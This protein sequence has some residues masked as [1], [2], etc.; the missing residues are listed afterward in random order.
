MGGVSG[1]QLAE[2]EISQQVIPQLAPVTEQAP[3]PVT[4]EHGLPPAPAGGSSVITGLPKA[5]A[6]L[7]KPLAP[8][9]AVVVGGGSSSSLTPIP[10]AVSLPNSA[11]DARVLEWEL[12][13]KDRL[14]NETAHEV[15][16]LADLMI[17][18]E[19]YN[20]TTLLSLS[21]RELLTTRSEWGVTQERWNNIVILRRNIIIPK[22]RPVPEAPVLRAE[23]EE[24][25]LSPAMIIAGALKVSVMIRA[26][27]ILRAILEL[28]PTD[29][30][31]KPAN[32]MKIL[33]S[34]EAFQRARSDG[35]HKEFLV[36]LVDQRIFESLRA[37][38]RLAYISGIHSW[39][40]FCDL[41][42]VEPSKQLDVEEDMVCI[43]LSLFRNH[44]TAAS[45]KSHLKLACNLA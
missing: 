21:E 41:M 29:P 44:K 26:D 38:S 30:I 27:S 25:Q 20:P 45:Y 2:A 17:R 15:R 35:I 13:I 1:Y 22:P 23:P 34:K 40:H 16:F 31:P 18:Q 9:A 39:V 36:G 19:Y 11:A 24:K 37:S 10:A 14:P 33:G 43:W 5:W 12:W 6:H 42:D 8:A 32:V 28:S 7:P 3:P 4:E